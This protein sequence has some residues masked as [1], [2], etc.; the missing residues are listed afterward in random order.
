ME[1]NYKVLIPILTFNFLFFSIII[2]FKITFHKQKIFCNI[3]YR[4]KANI[5]NVVYFSTADIDMIINNMGE[6]CIC[7]T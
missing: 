3:D 4:D 2:L 6:E 7:L 1:C 5:Y